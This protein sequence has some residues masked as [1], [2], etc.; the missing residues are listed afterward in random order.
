MNTNHAIFCLEK[1]KDFGTLQRC[2]MHNFRKSPVENA[3]PSKEH[4]NKELINHSAMDYNEL[5]KHKVKQIESNGGNVKKRKNSVIAYEIITTFSH[6]ATVDLESWKVANVRWMKKTFGEGN[7][8]SMQLHMD[9][10]GSPH[11]HTIVIPIDDNGH[12]NARAYTGGRAKM[13]N[14]H[15]SYAEAMEPFG[16]KRGTQYSV[17]K[18][19]NIRRFYAAVE[20]ALDVD[21]PEI[22]PYD[23]I[24]SYREKAQKKLEAERLKSLKEKYDLRKEIDSWRTKLNNFLKKYRKP[25][26]LYD[27]WES[28]YGTEITE[29]KFDALLH[30]DES[31]MDYI[32]LQN[33]HMISDTEILR[34]DSY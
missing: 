4:L 24:T 21:M 34:E 7:I 31:G 3:D 8:L 29:A 9:E 19:E 32:T 15:S 5:W 17:A 6:G 12:L 11:I 13:F 30:I 25:K 23:T 18:H 16:L 33:E 22:E 1:I 27:K 20:E 14:L 2:H 26:K 28:K 10:E